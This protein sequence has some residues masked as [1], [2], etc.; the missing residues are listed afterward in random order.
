ML[1]IQYTHGLQYYVQFH[2]HQPIPTLQWNEICI[3]TISD[4]Y[5]IIQ[6]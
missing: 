1:R 5:N 3:Y 6:V 4:S 2:F